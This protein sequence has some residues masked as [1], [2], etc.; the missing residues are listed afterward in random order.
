MTEMASTLHRNTLHRNSKSK[1]IRFDTALNWED[2]DQ[3]TAHGVEVRR[4]RKQRK[5]ERR[6]FRN[7]QEERVLETFT[8]LQ[9][10]GRLQAVNDVWNDIVVRA[11][12]TS[13]LSAAGAHGDTL[14]QQLDVFQDPNRGFQYRHLT[15][16]AL[17][18]LRLLALD[19][20]FVHEFF[21]AAIASSSSEGSTDSFHERIA[22]MYREGVVGNG[23]E[24]D[25]AANAGNL[26]ND[27][28]PQDLNQDN[29]PDVDVGEGNENGDDAA[30]APEDDVV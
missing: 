27:A 1:S 11:Q 23:N 28:A 26:A 4:E 15:L 10:R 19:E 25:A 2:E 14:D 20:V 9:D 6:M 3:R 7:Q 5:K 30:G 18:F 13:F 24:Q 21:P 22:D 16:T 12:I 8:V 17:R 29:D